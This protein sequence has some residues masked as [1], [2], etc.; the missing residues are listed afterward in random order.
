VWEKK[1]EKKKKK[2]ERKKMSNEFQE[3]NKEK[4][5]LKMLFDS[6]QSE[7]FVMR[8]FFSFSRR[9]RSRHFGPPFPFFFLF[10]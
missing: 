1:K 10:S 8:I 7:F 5:I 3:A 9:L 2:E 6:S 4:D